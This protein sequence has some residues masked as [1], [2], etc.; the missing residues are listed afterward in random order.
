LKPESD[1]DIFPIPDNSTSGD[2]NRVS[3]KLWARLLSAAV[4]LMIQY[5]CESDSVRIVAPVVVNPDMVSKSE[6]V[7]SNPRNMN[8]NDPK[9]VAKSQARATIT[10][11]SLFVTSPFSPMRL[12]IRPAEIV[13]KEERPK[14]ITPAGSL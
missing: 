9:I 8:G 6:S 12:I 2:L 13:I 1:V 11:A 10:K 4:E 3:I 14:A 7:S 5:P